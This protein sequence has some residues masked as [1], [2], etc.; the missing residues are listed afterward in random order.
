[1]NGQKYIKVTILKKQ[2][3]CHFRD[4]VIGLEK[5]KKTSAYEEDK[6]YWVKKE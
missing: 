5:I 6:K 4:Y 2:S 3:D 1:M